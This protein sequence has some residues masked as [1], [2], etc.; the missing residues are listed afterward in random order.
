MAENLGVLKDIPAPDVNTNGQIMAW[1]MD[2]YEKILGRKA[3]GAFTGKPIALGGSLG[4]EEATGMG[5]VDTLINWA[6]KMN[7]KPEEVTVAVQGFGNVGFWFAKL[8]AEAG[9]KV[10]AVSDSK[11]GITVPQEEYGGRSLNVDE[12]KKHKKE[13]GKV[14]GFPNTLEI[15]NEALLELPVT[16]L[17]PAALEQVINANNAPKIRAEVIIEMANGPVTPE[18]D[19]ILKNRGLV[20]IPDVLANA[21][22]VT[23]SYFEW[24]QNLQSYYWTKEE[25]LSKLHRV[26]ESAFETIWE[27]HQQM[28]NE[29]MRMA[30]YVIAVKRVVEAMRL[31]GGVV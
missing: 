30:T 24:V 17:V 1:M 5:G 18:A 7:R 26:M 3:P 12:I 27:Q 8:A 25:V 6:K 20:S 15:S 2:E 16:V 13:T 19:E 31:R 14:A 23:V 4:R 21:G 22:G 11:G 28:A 9:F 29:S 10:V